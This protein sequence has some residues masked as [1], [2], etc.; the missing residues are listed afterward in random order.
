MIDAQPLFFLPSKPRISPFGFPLYRG[1]PE[2]DPNRNRLEDPG[3]SFYSRIIIELFTTS[4]A[5][6]GA[7]KGFHGTL[8]HTYLI[9]QENGTLY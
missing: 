1:K 8:A 2:S 3:P 9:R 4:V 5:L 6:E 7:P